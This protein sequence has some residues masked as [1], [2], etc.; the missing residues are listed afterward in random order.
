MTMTTEDLYLLVDLV[1]TTSKE[2]QQL[3]E[4]IEMLDGLLSAMDLSFDESISQ[5]KDLS[6]DSKR[7]AARELMRQNSQRY[8]ANLIHLQELKRSRANLAIEKEQSRQMLEV[9]KLE[10]KSLMIK[11]ELTMGL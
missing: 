11:Q 7:K 10:V 1:T 8:Q 2:I 6:N 3:S 4:D 5:M 9:G